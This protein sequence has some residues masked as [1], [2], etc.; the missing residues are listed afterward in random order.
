[1]YAI[2]RPFMQRVKKGLLEGVR[3]FKFQIT[4]PKVFN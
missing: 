1:M 4:L 3:F 2:I